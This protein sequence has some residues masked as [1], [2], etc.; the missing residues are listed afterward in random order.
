MILSES[1]ITSW[2]HIRFLSY[3]IKL[4]ALKQSLTEELNIKL[5]EQRDICSE[6]IV[7]AKLSPGLPANSESQLLFFEN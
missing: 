6:S 5:W 2:N 1:S 7:L 3:W 4:G